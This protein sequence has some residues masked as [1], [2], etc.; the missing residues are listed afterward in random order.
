[1]SA[2]SS[3]LAALNSAQDRFISPRINWTSLLTDEV[4]AA[5]V[6]YAITMDDP[7]SESIEATSFDCTSMLA[8]DGKTLGEWG[9][10]PT[11]IRV[12]AHS[13]KHKVLPLRHL[14][15]VTRTPDWGLQAGAAE[16][17]VIASKHTGGLS[18]AERTLGTR[19][20]VGYIP[21]TILNISTKYR[22]SNANTATP[23]LVDSNNNVV[24]TT[25]WQQHLR[26]DKYRRLPGDH[27]IP[28]VMNPMVEIDGNVGTASTTRTVTLNAGQLW[29]FSTPASND[30]DSWGEKVTAWVD[31]LDWAL[32]RSEA[33]TNSKTELTWDTAEESSDFNAKADPGAN[34]VK[35]LSRY[36]KV[37]SAF[38]VDGI[39]R[40]GSK[41]SSPF[42]Y[43]RGGKTVL[44]TGFHS[45][46]AVDSLA[47]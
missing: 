25:E 39:R 3:S 15:D 23:I 11:A 27:I 41:R 32:V 12:K 28:A 24:G 18:D 10:S 38:K 13:K 17:T 35:I 33:G 7:N 45:T 4:I 1:M 37:G 43:F 31:D 6:E 2:G 29:L 34:N 44:T 8:A 36:A 19:L 40:A 20:D 14:F 47:L 42:L 26:G 9:V 30:S 5:A 21:R 46:S 16:D 22:G